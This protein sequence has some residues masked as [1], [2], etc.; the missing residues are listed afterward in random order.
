MA[1]GNITENKIIRLDHFTPGIYILHIINQGG[2][3]SFH[4]AFIKK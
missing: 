1:C 2:E 4:K 3:K